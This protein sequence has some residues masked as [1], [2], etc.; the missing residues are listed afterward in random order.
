MPSPAAND[1]PT[2]SP[3]GGNIRAAREAKGWTQ[4]ELKDVVGV[5]ESMT[6]SRWERNVSVPSTAN[7]AALAEVLDV[8]IGWLYTDH[9]VTGAAA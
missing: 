4:Q 2:T 5:E 9:S 8:T 3:L 6:I 1:R 7:L